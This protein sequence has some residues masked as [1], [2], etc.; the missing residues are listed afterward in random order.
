[1]LAHPRMPTAM[2]TT[3]T[4]HMETGSTTM[5]ASQRPSLI[6]FVLNTDRLGVLIPGERVLGKV[7]E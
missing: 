1:M 2:I 7:V 4:M 3:V 6:L 5:K